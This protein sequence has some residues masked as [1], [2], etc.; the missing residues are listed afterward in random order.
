MWGKFIYAT[1][2]STASTVPIFTKLQFPRALPSTYPSLNCRKI[3]KKGKAWW[4]K[5]KKKKGFMPWHEALHPLHQN[6]WNSL[7]FN[8]L[9]WRR[10]LSNFGPVG[11]KVQKIWLKIN[12]CPSV[13]MSYCSEFHIT[14]DLSIMYC[15]HIMCTEF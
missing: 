3:N 2:H 6:S 7:S 12:L 8:K 13:N 5:K 9:L 11:W 4:A 15:V 14:R 10:S 1:L